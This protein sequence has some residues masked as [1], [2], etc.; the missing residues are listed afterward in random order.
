MTND[1]SVAK[2]AEKWRQTE[3]DLFHQVDLIYYPSQ[4]EI[5]EILRNEPELPAKALPLYVLEDEQSAP[6]A[7]SEREGMLFVGGFE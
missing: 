7:A 6:Y 1:A 5:D 2:E 3:Y 4:V